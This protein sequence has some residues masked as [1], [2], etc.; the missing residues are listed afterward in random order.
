MT[1][2]GE[3]AFDCCRS[4]TSIN[5]PSSVVSLEGNPFARW[6]GVLHNKSKAFIYEDDVLFNKDKTILIAYRSKET[7]YIIPKTVTCIGEYAFY[8]CSSLISVDIP[9]SVTSIGDSA[10]YICSSLTCIDI[11]NSVTN[12]GNSAFSGCK[13]LTS[14]NIPTSVTNIGNWAFGECSSLPSQ[15]K[16]DIF[17]RFGPKVF[18]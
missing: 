18:Y 4:L 3:L 10:F 8:E 9:D 15:I 5:I 6:S 14:I 7:S 16:S 1:S 17:N 12:I 11:P 2:I 13:S